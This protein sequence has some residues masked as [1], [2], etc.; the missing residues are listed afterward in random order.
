MPENNVT[1]D[2]QVDHIGAVMTLHARA[3]RLRRIVIF[4]GFALAVMA[5][6]LLSLADWRITAA[7][8]LLAACALPLFAR[9]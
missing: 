1:Y 8:W 6:A 2:R 5:T 3:A 4:Q 7:A 9:R